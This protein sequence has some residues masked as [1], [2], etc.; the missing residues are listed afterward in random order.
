MMLEIKY[1]GGIRTEF[2]HIVADTHAER[3]QLGW[4]YVYDLNKKRVCVAIRAFIKQRMYALNEPKGSRTV[5]AAKL[6]V[7]INYFTDFHY[8]KICKV[9]S[10]HRHVVEDIAPEPKSAF[11]D[12]YTKVIIPILYECDLMK[13]G[14]TKAYK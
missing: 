6:L 14:Q 10:D 3:E 2:K 8:F 11:Y 4:K 1:P 7:M 9:I 5:A 12:H 13:D